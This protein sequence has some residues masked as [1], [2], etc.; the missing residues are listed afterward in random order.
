M[1]W[2]SRAT[3]CRSCCTPACRACSTSCSRSRAFAADAVLS[4]ALASASSPISRR[5]ALLSRPRYQPPASSGATTDSTNSGVASREDGTSDPA[6]AAVSATP[7][8]AA[9]KNAHRASNSMNAYTHAVQDTSMNQ[10]SH[11][12]SPASSTSS[13]A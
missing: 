7:P 5:R 12:V 8:A 6:C 9:P 11:T 10:G 4:P 3:R 13:P 1:S 2:I